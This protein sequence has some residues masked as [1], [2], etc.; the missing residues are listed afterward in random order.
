MPSASGS[1]CLAF[2]FIVLK[3]HVRVLSSSTNVALLLV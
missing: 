2:S 3:E 1:D